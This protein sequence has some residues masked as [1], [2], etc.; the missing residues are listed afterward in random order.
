MIFLK[1]QSWD[2]IGKIRRADEFFDH[3]GELSALAHTGVPS[4]A[5]SGVCITGDALARRVRPLWVAAR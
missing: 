5:G 3:T 4:L 1:T 2:G